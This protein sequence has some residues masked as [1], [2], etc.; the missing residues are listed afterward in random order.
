MAPAAGEAGLASG[1]TP[2]LIR[3]RVTRVIGSSA[4]CGV[5]VAPAVETHSIAFAVFATPALLVREAGIEPA[6][7]LWTMD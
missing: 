2:G 7:S 3:N 5:R 4:G 1:Q 6:V